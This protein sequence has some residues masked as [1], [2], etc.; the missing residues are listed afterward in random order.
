M[1]EHRGKNTLAVK[2]IERVSVGVAD[3]GG[4]DL[5]QDFAGLGTIE[6]DLDD[7][8]RLLGLEGDGG[9]CLHMRFLYSQAL[10]G[11]ALFNLQ[12]WIVIVGQQN[13]AIT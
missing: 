4:L 12:A 1:A 7:F 6:V 8:Q 9:T 2:T 11:L 3:S 13:T 5:D 10:C